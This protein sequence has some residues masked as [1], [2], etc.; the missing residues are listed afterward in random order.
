MKIKGM[1]DIKM[2]SPQRERILRIL[3][4]DSQFLASV[5][6]IDYSLLVG[7]HVKGSSQ[8]DYE[9]MVPPLIT[10]RKSRAIL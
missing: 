2:K 9:N 8:E 4:L 7:V 10:D 1:V 5:Q 6:V 3:K